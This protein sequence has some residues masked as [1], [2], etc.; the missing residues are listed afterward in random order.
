MSIDLSIEANI[1]V[2][3]LTVCNVGVTD[4]RMCEVR[5]WDALRWHD[6]NT[7]QVPWNSVQG[8]KSCRS[9]RWHDVHTKQ[10]PW[11][12]V[13]EFKSCWSLRRHDVHTKQVPWN[14]VQ[15]FKSCWGEQIHT[16]SKVIFHF[17]LI[18]QNKE[19]RLKT[20]FSAIKGKKE[21]ITHIRKLCIWIVSIF[22]WVTSCHTCVQLSCRLCDM[23]QKT[24]Y[25]CFCSWGAKSRFPCRF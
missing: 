25:C 23:S 1:K 3:S 5:R 16:K 24:H 8:F 12:L 18:F 10:V 13:Q 17:Y 14:S 11:N 6:V 21:D 15:G 7:N 20:E 9:L 2:N 4:G 19:S 22:D